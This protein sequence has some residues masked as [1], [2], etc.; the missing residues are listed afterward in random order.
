M[1]FKFALNGG[2]EHIIEA[3]WNIIEA[4]FLLVSLGVYVYSGSRAEGMLLKYNDN[5]RKRRKKGA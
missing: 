1:I 5:T 2:G 3:V 4:A